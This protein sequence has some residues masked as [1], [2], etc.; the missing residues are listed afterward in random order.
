MKSVAII[1]GWSEGPWQSKRFVAELSKSSLSVTK[2]LKSADIIFAHSAGCYLV[3]KDVP[4]QTIILVGLPYWP[5]RS[6]LSS[7][8]KNLTVGL[9]QHHS[10]G[11]IK[12]WFSK[13]AHNLYY[14]ITRP[15]ANWYV[16]TRHKIENLPISN[17]GK[18]II[19]V[20]NQEDTFCHPDVQKLVQR[21]SE[22]K[23]IELPGA[24]DNCWVNPAKYIN[25]IRSTS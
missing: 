17:E 11:D 7:V 2:D 8:L 25:L 19:L 18:K 1:Y 14:I 20:R 9:R 3:P 16:L 6:S 13:L 15:Q 23:F 24:H 22:Y 5:G 21:V 12:W 4:A 10:E